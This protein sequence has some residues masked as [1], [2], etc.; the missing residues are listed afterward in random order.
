MG[1]TTKSGVNY[2]II[3]SLANN[4]KKGYALPIN[5]IRQV[6]KETSSKAI[7]LN[8]FITPGEAL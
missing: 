2:A 4:K 7:F 1:R 3:N 5:L 6:I 8:P